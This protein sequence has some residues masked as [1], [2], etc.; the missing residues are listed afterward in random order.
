MFFRSGIANIPRRFVTFSGNCRSRYKRSHC[1]APVF[2]P[3]LGSFFRQPPHLA[4]HSPNISAWG[5]HPPQILFP[6]IIR[7]WRSLLPSSPSLWA[8]RS[9]S[10]GSGWARTS[11]YCR[12]PRAPT[13]PSTTNF[14]RFSSPL[15]A[16]FGLAHFQPGAL[17]Q[18]CRRC[19]RWSA[20]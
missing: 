4:P 17:S 8:W 2:I 14:L 6:S 5:P 12:W 1:G 13:P 18:A 19:I 20:H 10:P 11:P 16:H 3:C 9:C 7:T 15:A